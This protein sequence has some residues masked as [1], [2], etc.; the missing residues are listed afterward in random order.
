VTLVDTSIWVDHLRSGDPQLAELLEA[1]DVLIHPFVLGELALG[2]LRQRRLVLGDLANLPGAVLATDAEVLH[3]IEQA[4]L[5]G[6]GIGYID[7]HLLASTRLTPGAALWTRDLRLHSA[8]ETLRL[9]P[10]PARS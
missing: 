2:S 8:A 1:G 9:I 5:H 10:A 7:A 3:L 4:R 6:R